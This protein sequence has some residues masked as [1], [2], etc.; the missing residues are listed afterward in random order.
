MNIVLAILYFSI[1]LA[2]DITSD[3]HKWKINIP[4]NHT[5]EAG[6]RILI[7]IPSII[8]LSIPH[9]TII[10]LLL[11]ILLHFSLWWI[12]F[13]GFYN[14]LRGY[15]WNYTGSIDDDDATLDKVLRKLGPIWSNILKI[16]ILIISLTFYLKN[17][18]T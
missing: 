16:S 9:F 5:K 12:I 3:V 11:S 4:I 8:L 14:L 13:D 15:D 10:K 1:V 2:W 6:I 18:V 17:Y 7:L